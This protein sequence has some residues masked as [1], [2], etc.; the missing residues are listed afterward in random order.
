[1]ETTN[2]TSNEVLTIGKTEIIELPS[3]LLKFITIGKS[4]HYSLGEVIFPRVFV[5]Q[6]YSGNGH[7]TKL[8]PDETKKTAALI[9]AAPK[10][11]EALIAGKK[12]MNDA[13]VFGCTIIDEAIKKATEIPS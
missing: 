3:L 1:M 5:I 2:N 7:S 10:M 12:C 11:L 8:T 6:E 9:A 4:R 13:G